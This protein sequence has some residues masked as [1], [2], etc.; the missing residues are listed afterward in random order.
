ME[1]KA[2]FYFLCVKLVNVIKLIACFVFGLVSLFFKKSSGLQHDRARVDI[3]APGKRKSCC[4]YK[5]A[6]GTI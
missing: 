5:T 3:A 6:A 4:K 1:L 2:S